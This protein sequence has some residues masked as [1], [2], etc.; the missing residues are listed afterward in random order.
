MQEQY[1]SRELELMLERLESPAWNLGSQPE[2]PATVS[3]AAPA[4]VPAAYQAKVYHVLVNQKVV[5]MVES[6]ICC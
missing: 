4:R 3:T 2:R 5:N 1:L 6:T